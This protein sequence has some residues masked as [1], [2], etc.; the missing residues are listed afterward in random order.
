[1]GVNDAAEAIA[2]SVTIDEDGSI[3]VAVLQGATDADGDNV[4]LD[5]VTQGANGSVVIESDGTVT[6]EANADFNGTD[7]FTFTL[8]DG[9]GGTVTETVNVTV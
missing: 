4:G 7:S 1:M 3:N 2:K 8:S 6:Y 5:S 9:N